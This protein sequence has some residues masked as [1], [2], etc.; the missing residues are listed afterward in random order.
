MKYPVHTVAT[1][2]PS[3]NVECNMDR[4]YDVVLALIPLALLGI[5]GAL[6]VAGVTLQ[7]AVSLS[8]LT[9]A[10]LIGHAVFVNGPVDVTGGD[11]G[12]HSS[13]VGPVNAD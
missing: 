10:A 11:S 12:D 4:Y 6:L 1:L 8:G 3:V 9:A 13:G 5:G 2:I 7:L